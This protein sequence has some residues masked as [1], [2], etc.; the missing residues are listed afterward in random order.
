MPMPRD[1]VTVAYWPIADMAATEHRG[2]YS[3]QNEPQF[4]NRSQ[5]EA[6]L[7]SRSVLRGRFEIGSQACSPSSKTLACFRSSVSK[8]SVKQP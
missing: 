5:A 6:Q 8:P 1:A 3:G 7:S 2:S 4:R